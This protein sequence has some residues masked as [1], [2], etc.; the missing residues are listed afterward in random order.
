MQ[1]ICVKYKEY[2]GQ[3][4]VRK[5]QLF[6]PQK[7]QFWD[8]FIDQE[9]K[10]NLKTNL[11]GIKTVGCDVIY[12]LQHMH[13]E[14]DFFILYVLNKFMS[15]IWSFCEKNIKELLYDTLIKHHHFF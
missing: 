5:L 13:K 12:L 1:T 11:F 14:L 15:F 3:L 6:Y 9:V 10:Y 2:Y 8:V 4:H 7:K